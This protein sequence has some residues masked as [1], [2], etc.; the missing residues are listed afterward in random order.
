[1]NSLYRT[2][3]MQSGPALSA[4]A[5]F[6][7][8]L[9]VAAAVPSQAQLPTPTILYGFQQLPTDVIEPT[10]PIAQ[11]RDG[12][13]YGVGVNRGA[14]NRGGVYRIT[15][16]GAE[17]LLVSFPT[18]YAEG[19]CLGLTLGMD[20]NFYGTCYGGG[21]NG[22]GLFYKVTQ[23]GVLTDL[24]DFTE[25]GILVQGAPVL[26]ADGNFYGTTSDNIY[27]IT[28][29]GVYKSLFTL[30]AGSGNANPSV[31][32]AGSDG[33]FYG[34]IAD[35]DGFGNQGGVFRITPSGAFKVIYGFDS[36]SAAGSGP[37]IG[38]T[39]GSNGRLYGTTGA[40]GTNSDGVIYEMTTAGKDV[41]VLHNI[42]DSTEGAN[43]TGGNGA[44]S[45]NLLLQA[46]DGN[47]YGANLG[48]GI[49]NEGGLYQ[50]TSTDA[51]SGFLF[52][53]L[54]PP[55]DGTQPSG[56]LLQ[57]TNGTIFG[58]ANSNGPSEDDGTVFSLNI[59]A[60]PF[61]KLVT[62]VYEGKEETQ[63]GILGQGFGG[64]SVV[65]FGGTAATT[66]ELTGTTFILATV[67][68]GA[69][70]GKVT[71]TTGSTTLSTSATYKI[72]P[73]LNTFAP[74]SG[75]VGTSVTITGTGLEQTTKVTIDKIAAT[76]TVDSDSQ[77]T[78]VV[79]TGASTGKIAVITKGGSATSSASFTVN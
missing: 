77:V 62:P 42:N 16:S 72:T 35:A 29:A 2:T 22:F 57:H 8:I 38:V 12:N 13:L 51:F 47:F 54:N 66:T 43:G 50:L 37:S 27:R 31:L 40:G 73:T 61:I 25:V 55:T 21:A 4:L 5:L 9:I 67:P 69:L 58:I 30:V 7:V 79:P 75:P 45:E 59:G 56:P 1:M 28:P 18:S 23:A 26:G 46:T 48:G 44:D 17:S 68:S 11:G 10:G 20:G 32:N 60:S 52:G 14:N 41:L 36:S 53:S 24:Y 49:G 3:K 34:T 6:V 33:N 70:T 64:S 15:P 63:V 74:S 65:K 19:S 71:V 78:A 76:F 39:M